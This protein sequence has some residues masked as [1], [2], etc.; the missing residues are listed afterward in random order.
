MIN[1][2]DTNMTLLYVCGSWNV[3]SYFK[4]DTISPSEEV[5]FPT[6]GLM[7]CLALIIAFA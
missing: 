2:N 3:Q 6:Y 4:F 5:V 1:N 7:F